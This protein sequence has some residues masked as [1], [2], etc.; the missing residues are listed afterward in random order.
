MKSGLNNNNP[1]FM[2]LI[3]INII[4]SLSPATPDTLINSGNAGL[5]IPL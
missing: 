4:S 2:L 3:T 5:N 1:D